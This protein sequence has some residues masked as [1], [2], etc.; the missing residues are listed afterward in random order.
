MGIVLDASLILLPLKFIWKMNAPIMT[1]AYVFMFFA[2]R[3]VSVVFTPGAGIGR[4]LLTELTFRVIGAALSKLVFLN[5][6]APSSD[7]FFGS[8]V[9]TLCSQVIQCLNLLSACVLYLRPF[10]RSLQSVFERTDDLRR[11]GFGDLYT[12]QAQSGSDGSRW[13]VFKGGSKPRFGDFNVALHSLS[14]NRHTTT[15][16][17]GDADLELHSASQHSRA[18]IIRQT[19]TFEVATSSPIVG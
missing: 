17:S 3:I 2:F 16:V 4:R 6:N 15:V 18:Y 12:G 10:L 9:V 19:R 14:K 1:R 8:W 13:S 7:V 5:R 11:Q